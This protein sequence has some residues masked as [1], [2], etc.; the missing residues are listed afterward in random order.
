MIAPWEN[1]KDSE[2]PRGENQ[3]RNRESGHRQKVPQRTG[4]SWKVRREVTSVRDEY[5]HWN[6]LSI[7]LLTESTEGFV[8]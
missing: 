3:G 4:C 5:S 8:F 2:E 1:W 6:V 7:R